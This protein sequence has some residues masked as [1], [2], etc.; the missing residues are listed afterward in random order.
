MRAITRH[1]GALRAAITA[2]S[3]SVACIAAALCAIGGLASPIPPLPAHPEQRSVSPSSTPHPVINEILYE[4]DPSLR[5][6]QV[7]STPFV[8]L[9]HPAVPGS[10]SLA[11]CILQQA[12]SPYWRLELPPSV[13]HPT[14]NYFVVKDC[15]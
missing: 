2:R 10:A 7:G 4:T 12:R 8:E 13:S 6:R 5:R 1:R 14:D 9:F 11:G 3:L 15:R